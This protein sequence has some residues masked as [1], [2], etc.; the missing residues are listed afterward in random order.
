M[1]IK[2][3]ML[4]PLAA[5]LFLSCTAC[6]LP[7][8][9][10]TV[11]REL[12]ILSWN[13]QNLF[14][15]VSDGG[16][17]EE[18]DPAE[19][20]WTSAL[21]QKRLDRFGEVFDDVLEFRPDIV[22]LQEM[23]N[24]NTLEILGNDVLKG[25]YPWRVLFE[26]KDMSVHTA[27]LSSLPIT[28]TARLETGYWGQIRLRPL[29]EVH[30]DLQGNEMILFNNHWKSRSGGV[31]A[32]EAGRISAARILVSRIRNLVRENPDALIV[33]GGDFN[34]N[35]DEYKRTGRR[36]RTALIPLIEDVS[37]EWNDSLFLC[38]D[39]SDSG[40]IGERLALYSPWFDS[41]RAGSY[42]YKSQWEKIDHFFLWKSFF[43]GRDY[44]FLK[45]DVIREAPL[46]NEYNYPAR[47]DSGTEEG[48]SDHLPI[49]LK[50]GVNDI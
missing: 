1:K 39:G 8:G 7:F 47:W 28:E 9:E 34:E 49:L 41:S 18:F 12:T 37:E 42:A 32:T 30:F 5:L 11:P 22:L 17:Y 24:L 38:S 10:E 50:I 16:E 35:H 45:F 25:R 23:E 3:L 15:D 29:Q 6:S 43:D 20:E 19:G 26:E 31:A 40:L 36:Y 44:E 13:V 2:F 21:F 14:D 46:L 27:V 4:I 48:Y 33:A